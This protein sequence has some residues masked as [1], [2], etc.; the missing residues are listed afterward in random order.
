MLTSSRAL[1]ETRTTTAITMIS[2]QK[3]IKKVES[4]AI[5]LDL[6]A[7]VSLLSFFFITLS[8]LMRR[9]V[10]YHMNPDGAPRLPHQEIGIHN[11]KPNNKTKEK[12]QMST[13]VKWN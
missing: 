11:Q 8:F 1:P 10:L 7:F 2:L 4:S 9:Y 6:N 5:V 12:S 13:K 3:K